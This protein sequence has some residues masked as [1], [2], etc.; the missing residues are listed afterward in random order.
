LSSKRRR[1]SSNLFGLSWV[2]FQIA[3]VF[4][5]E[6]QLSYFLGQFNVFLL[7]K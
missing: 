6:F 1:R 4:V 5:A 3:D 7:T 2:A